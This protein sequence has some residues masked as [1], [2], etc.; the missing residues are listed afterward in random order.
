MKIENALMLLVAMLFGLAILFLLAW[1]N[2]SHKVC[3]MPV[4]T[5]KMTILGEDK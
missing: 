2:R 4:P 1:G 5:E 3:T